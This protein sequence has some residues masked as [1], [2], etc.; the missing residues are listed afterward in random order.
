MI[1]VAAYGVTALL[2]PGPAWAAADD[3]T[4]E[5][6]PEDAGP[7]LLPAADPEPPPPPPPPRVVPAPP[8]FSPSPAAPPARANGVLA[9][10]RF[11]VGVERA[12]GG[13][14][15]RSTLAA[16]PFPTTGPVRIGWDREVSAGHITSLLGASASYGEL[17]EVAAP[18]LL[19]RVAADVVL[20][21]VVTVGGAVGF[22]SSTGTRDLTTSPS[23]TTARDPERSGLLLAPRVGFL[24]ALGPHLALWL[25][26][27]VAY[28]STTVKQIDE[29]A[30]L[31]TREVW[32]LNA[33]L[34]PALVWSPTGHL[35]FLLN[36][37]TDVGLAGRRRV[38]VD[39]QGA[40]GEN[41]AA[42]RWTGYG[43]SL[44]MC[45]FL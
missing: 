15:W 41:Q 7:T 3:V 35:G 8:L 1:V 10:A 38:S 4:P 11:I 19:P 30:A 5:A 42:Y 12:F 44:A 25:R 6:P 37:F 22:F 40:S 29:T 34:D 26:A 13:V 28:A 20:R 27:G 2:L 23:A 16:A 18:S 33:S 31:I 45:G 24:H 9:G 14:L 36:P 21:E 17:S 39:F 43:V 32:H